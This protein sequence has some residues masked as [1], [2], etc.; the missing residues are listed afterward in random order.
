MSGI[1]RIKSWHTLNRSYLSERFLL[2]CVSISSA[3]QTAGI[4]WNNVVGSAGFDLS[5]T[6]TLI[7]KP[8]AEGIGEVRRGIIYVRKIV[9]VN[10]YNLL[11]Y[12]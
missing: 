2:L 12:T 4:T 3:A 5:G 8:D 11:L 10:N 1:N 7:D 9:L 6:S